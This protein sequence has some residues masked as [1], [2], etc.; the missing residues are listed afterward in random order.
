M[1]D[2]LSQDFNIKLRAARIADGQEQPPR[3]IMPV[4][5]L[6]EAHYGSNGVIVDRYR[7]PTS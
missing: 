5:R 2:R 4:G 3:N 1:S 7:H 6:V